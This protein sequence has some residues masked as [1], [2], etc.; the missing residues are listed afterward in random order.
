MESTKKLVKSYYKV[1]KHLCC[2]GLFGTVGS[3][4][5]GS[6]L[7]ETLYQLG[8]CQPGVMSTV[9]NGK[10]CIRFQTLHKTFLI[11]I[12]RLYLNKIC[13]ID[14]PEEQQKESVT[15]YEELG[16]IRSLEYVKK[17]FT[18]HPSV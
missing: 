11:A 7:E 17:Y 3:Y 12:E 1:T 15:H 13:T 18:D 4:I 9:L 8:M 10:H 14:V 16:K 6:A 5:S 2:Y